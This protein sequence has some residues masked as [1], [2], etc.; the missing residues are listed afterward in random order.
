[1]LNSESRKELSRRESRRK[2]KNNV[3]RGR[4]LGNRG[5][6]KRESGGKNKRE[7]GKSGSRSKRFSVRRSKRN[8]MRDGRNSRKRES[9]TS[10]KSK[11]DA[12]PFGSKSKLI[13]KLRGGRIKRNMRPG[14]R[15]RTNRRRSL[16]STRW[17][18]MPNGR[19]GI[20]RT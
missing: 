19:P 20:T 2:E 13:L 12:K 8:I 1:M 6:K 9:S 11:R 15:N 18:W 14:L 10:K 17:R 4:E 3:W 7:T 16:K 5:S